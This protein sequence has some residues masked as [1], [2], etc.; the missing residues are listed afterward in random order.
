MTC[1]NTVLFVSY[2]Y[3]LSPA[4]SKLSPLFNTCGHAHFRS[5][6][7]AGDVTFFNILHILLKIASL[8][9]VFFNDLVLQSVYPVLSMQLRKK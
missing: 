4:F 2:L 7:L 5:G 6:T 9:K 1:L 8:L 3:I